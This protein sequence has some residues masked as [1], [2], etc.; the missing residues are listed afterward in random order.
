SR[1]FVLML[2]DV[3]LV[4]RPNCVAVLAELIDRFPTGSTL[5][6]AGRSD[7][8][9]PL[10]RALASHRVLRID[11]TD[12]ALTTS[13]CVAVLTALDVEQAAE[14]GPVLAE[15]TEGWPVGISLAALTLLNQPDHVAAAARFGGNNR[16]V[17]DYFAQEVLNSL[18]A[19]E[20]E[21]LLRASTLDVLSGPLCDAVLQRSDSGDVLER[22][23]RSNTFVISLD[24]EGEQYRFHGMFRD[25]LRTSLVRQDRTIVRELHRRASAWHVEHGDLD[26][27][28]NHSYQA[29]DAS[30]V[31]ALAW[32]GVASHLGTGR[33][34]V[35]GR[36]LHLFS[37][38]KIGAEPALAL[39]AAWWSLTTGRVG[40][41][42]HWLGEAERA[43]PDEVLPDGTP[44]RPATLLLRALIGRHGP[45]EVC[46]DAGLAFELAPLGSPYRCIA[47]Y[48]EGSALRLLGKASLARDRLEDGAALAT[49]AVPAV[50]A[51]C[52]CQLALLAID[53]DDWAAA[54]ELSTTATRVVEAHGLGERPTMAIH[55]AIQ[56]FFAARRVDH[57]NARGAHEHAAALLAQLTGDAPWFRALVQ[58]VLGRAALQLGDFGTARALVAEAQRFAS[59]CPDATILRDQVVQATRMIEDSPI[60]GG[61][62]A[63]ALTPAELRVL[64]FLPTQ[65]SFLELGEQLFVSRNTVK[66]QVHSVYR[67]L[68]VSSRTAA[69]ERA[70]EVG[71]LDR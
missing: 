9:L 1:P 31:S 63:P 10:G 14:V 32:S 6:L 66:T 22:L 24:E 3:H 54:D 17:V 50:H 48:L 53:E 27:A 69:V 13:E 35:V 16:N 68:C 19:T 33:S 37:A 55:Y 45:T 70:R 44:V 28:I 18:S 11:H 60:P 38:Q 25:A 47:R 41:V 23:S 52:L 57:L 7:I 20:V 61:R 21:F 8:A 2:D 51:H 67:K 43:E 26:S 65:L 40:D 30:E 42:E 29:G 39:T 58:L 59:K 62:G 36:W 71:L 15:R 56:A 5:V 49:I 64:H 46:T 4:R 34:G 12:L